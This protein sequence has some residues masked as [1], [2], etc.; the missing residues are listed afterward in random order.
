V[1]ALDLL[2]HLAATHS[3][4]TLCHF[5]KELRADVAS[6]RDE[7]ERL[8]KELNIDQSRMRK[9]S[10][11]LAEKITE[12]KLRFDDPKAGALLLFESLEALSLGIEGKRSLWIALAAIAETTPS[13]RIADYDRLQQRA[14]EQR[15]RVEA[16]RIETASTVLTTDG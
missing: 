6:D 5:F 2:D 8:M 1:V 9:A 3:E 13:M 14:Q 4:D 16:L 11:W 12:L 7:L 10:A 15:D